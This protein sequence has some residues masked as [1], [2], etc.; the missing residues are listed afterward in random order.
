M[1]KLN[2]IPDPSLKAAVELA[3]KMELPLF[4]TGE[5]GTGKTELAKWVAQNPE[6]QQ[7][8]GLEQDVLQFNVKTTSTAKDLLYRYDAIRHFRDN[9]NS[10]S[11]DPKANNVLHYIHFEALGQ[12][13]LASTHG[14]RHV[15]LVDE[16]DKAPRD[17]PNDLLF[18]FDKLGFRIDEATRGDLA[19]FDAHWKDMPSISWLGIRD[20]PA[21]DEQGFIYYA[22]KANRDQKRTERSIKKP[23][24]IMTSNSEKNL[25]DAFLRRCAF[26]HI[27]FPKDRS[28]LL[29]ILEAK[30]LYQFEKQSEL[31]STAVD[32]FLGIRSAGL[33]RNP[34][35]AELIAWVDFLW[36]MGI[37][38][39]VPLTANDFEKLEPSLSILGKN[40]EDLQR[41]KDQLTAM[42]LPLQTNA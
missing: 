38:P 27:P 16:I 5:P 21:M 23:V 9:Q 2:Y 20:R 39:A 42:T 6:Y 18:E 11:T 41:I 31:V 14:K 15:V 4:V 1:P 13:I 17:F 35:T 34:A 32:F 19:G 3:I 8:F 26:F 37:D 30:G 36:E 29:Q 25:P 7:Q 10:A 28:K 22:D 33:R 40:K 24:L 12:A